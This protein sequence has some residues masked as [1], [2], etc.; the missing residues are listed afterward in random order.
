ML[1]K[2]GEFLSSTPAVHVRSSLYSSCDSVTWILWTS[3]K[4]YLAAL[5]STLMLIR[6]QISIFGPE[7]V[8]RWYGD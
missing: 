8:V 3:L 6:T 4:I 7:N 5:G 2:K 1:A